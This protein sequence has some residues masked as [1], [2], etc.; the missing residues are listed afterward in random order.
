MINL[1][2]KQIIPAGKTTTLRQF[3]VLVHVKLLSNCGFIAASG[4]DQGEE[5]F[6]QGWLGSAAHSKGYLCI[7]HR[8]IFGF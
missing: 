5:T 7:R 6:G 3:F 2:V 1:N 4:Q 8:L